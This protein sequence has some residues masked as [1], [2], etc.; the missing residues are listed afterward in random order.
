MTFATFLD[1]FAQYGYLFILVICY[2]E[3]LNL[4]GF[5]AGLIMPGIGVLAGQSDL[6]LPG[7]LVLSIFAGTLASLTIYAIC[8]FG[9][10]P[11]LHKLFG[12]SKKFQRFVNECHCKIELHG[13]R[14]LFLCRLIA[15]LRTI[16][17]IPAGL[18][19]VPVR[20][21]TIWSAAGIACW[22]TVLIVTGYLGGNVVI[23][24]LT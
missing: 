24:C 12:K 19:K 8:R 13:N 14:A 16:V 2:C 7:A 18:L 21:Y 4:P 3:Y 5:P 1:F 10:A 11:L 9:G 6:N 20:D 15:V 23:A 22:N 17:S